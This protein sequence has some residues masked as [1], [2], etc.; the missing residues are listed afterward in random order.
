METDQKSNSKQVSLSKRPTRKR[1]S[2]V[3]N[4]LSLGNLDTDN[5]HYRLVT[6]E[7][8]NV[9]EFQERGYEIE[10]LKAVGLDRGR[11]EGNAGSDGRISVGGG[12]MAVLMKQKREFYEEDQAIKAEGIDNQM[13]AIEDSPEKEGMYGKVK[14]S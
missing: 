6:D 13:A 7:D 12:S 9:A 11:L 5:F 2:D 14:L 4:R 10:D 3:T 1:A 8:M